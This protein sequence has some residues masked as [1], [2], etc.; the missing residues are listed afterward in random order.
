MTQKLGSSFDVPPLAHEGGQWDT[1][2]GNHTS[3][4]IVIVLF[5]S[6]VNSTHVMIM[7]YFL[8]ILA[9]IVCLYLNPNIQRLL[10]L[11][12]KICH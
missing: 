1:A 2:D 3:F 7:A 11:L 5:V 9:R 10:F 8:N 12:S 6:S 4:R